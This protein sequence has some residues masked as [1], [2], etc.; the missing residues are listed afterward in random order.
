MANVRQT[1][2]GVFTDTAPAENAIEALH[3]AGFSNDQIRYSGHA[4]MGGGFW[5]NM[6]S[7]FTGA[8][9]TS[10]DVVNDLRSIGL[11]QDEASYYAQQHKA[12]HPIV[13]VNAADRA[14]DAAQILQTNGGYSYA[15]GSSAANTAYDQS[16]AYNQAAYDQR[17]D[18]TGTERYAQPNSYTTGDQYS[19][20]AD[21]AQANRFDRTADADSGDVATDEERRLRLRE[22][23]LQ[24]DKQAV[25]SGEVNIRKEVVTE[26][27]SIDVD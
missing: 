27:K 11:T 9:E 4:G 24:A 8:D 26:Q 16:T 15:A 6:K 23:R 21:Y 7:L 14:Q 22:E 1:I 18:Y 10:G 5:E 17:A 2:V 3:S 20:S 19:Q 25:E 12:G 13:A